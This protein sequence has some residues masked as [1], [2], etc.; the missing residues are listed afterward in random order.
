MLFKSTQQERVKTKI[1][2]RQIHSCS[3]RTLVWGRTEISRKFCFL[4]IDHLRSRCSCCHLPKIHVQFV[5]I[6]ASKDHSCCNLPQR[7]CPNISS[8]GCNLID[9]TKF[10][11]MLLDYIQS[12]E[13]QWWLRTWTSPRKKTQ[14]RETCTSTNFSLRKNE[15]TKK[16]FE[17]T[18][19]IETQTQLLTQYMNFAG[20]KF[21]I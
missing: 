20:K 13:K 7:A 17:K 3:A 21:D 1:Q 2:Q 9:T 4:M 16:W 19:Q 10:A 18:S 12:C 6:H 15:L 5:C 11:T 8:S 14:K